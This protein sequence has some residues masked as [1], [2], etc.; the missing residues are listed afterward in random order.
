MKLAY[1]QAK[2][3]QHPEDELLLFESYLLSPST[4]SPK[5]KKCIKD[6]YVCLNEV[7]RKWGWKWKIDH[8]DTTKIVL[9]LD[10]DTIYIKYENV[11]QYNYG[12]MY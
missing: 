9:G 5:S 10:M 2:A 7:T 4:L 3:K 8:I 6:K 1:N 11:S 12:Y